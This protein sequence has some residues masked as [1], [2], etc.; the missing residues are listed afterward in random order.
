MGQPKHQYQCMR[1]T[2]RRL[3]RMIKTAEAIRYSLQNS[4]FERSKMDEVILQLELVLDA[5]EQGI[6]ENGGV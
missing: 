6:R 4:K 5:V 3:S 2:R 1:N